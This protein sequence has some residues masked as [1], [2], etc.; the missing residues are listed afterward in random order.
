MFASKDGMEVL[1]FACF[2]EVLRP[3]M[4]F[5]FPF[6]VLSFPVTFLSFSHFSSLFLSLNLVVFFGFYFLFNSF[7]FPVGCSGFLH[8]PFIGFHSLVMF[9]ACSSHF[10]SFEQ[11][12]K[13][14][15]NVG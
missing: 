3:F 7:H 2:W 6:I 11:H 13:Q 12:Q 10:L 4:S 1:F 14:K 9:L 15:I 8:F 5:Q